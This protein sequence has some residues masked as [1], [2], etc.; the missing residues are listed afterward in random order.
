[1]FLWTHNNNHQLICIC[2]SLAAHKL[3]PTPYTPSLHGPPTT[4]VTLWP[5]QTRRRAAVCRRW[6]HGRPAGVDSRPDPTLT[7]TIMPLHVRGK[8]N[9]GRNT[10]QNVKKKT[11]KDQNEGPFVC[12]RS[13][14]FYSLREILLV[15]KRKH[16]LYIYYFLFPCFFFRRLHIEFLTLPLQ[17]SHYLCA[18]RCQQQYGK[19]FFVVVWI[20]RDQCFFRKAKL[21]SV[22]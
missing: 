20:V 18:T 9:R 17:F 21:P 12:D 19:G 5:A 14:I 16:F 7:Q 13:I 15:N 1:M 6:W 10:V 22:G 11:Q 3:H 2:V 4:A 8:S